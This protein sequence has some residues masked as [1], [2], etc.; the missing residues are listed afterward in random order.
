[1]KNAFTIAFVLMAFWLPAQPLQWT[2][3]KDGGIERS[4]IKGSFND[5]LEMSGKQ[6]SAIIYYGVDSSG[7]LL[8]RRRLVFP[9]LRTI[10]NDTHASLIQD[11]AGNP[12]A[13]A[14]INGEPL[15]ETPLRF[16]IQ[17]GLRVVTKAG[18][19][20]IERQIFPTVDKAA[21]LEQ[22]Q[23]RNDADQ[24]VSLTIPTLDS[25]YT[26]E[27]AKGVDGAYTLQQKLY[28]SADIR[29]M[30]GQTHTCWLVIS[31]RKNVQLPYYYSAPYEWERRKEKLAGLQQKLILQ[32]PNDT[33]NRMFAFAKVRAVESIYDTRE[34]L[35]HGPGGERY[36]AAIWA[37]DQAEYVNPFFAYLGDATGVESA[38]NSFRLFARYINPDFKPIPSSITAEGQDIWNGAGDRGDQAMIGYGASFFALTLGDKST[39]TNLWP[40]VS[41]CNRYLLKQQTAE[42][43][44]ASA[45]DELEGRFPAGK[46]NL[47]TNTLAYGSF[48]YSAR[49]A[50]WLGMADSALYWQQ[51]ANALEQHIETYFGAVVEGFNTYRYYDGNDK[52]RSWICLPL[53]MGINRRRDETTRALLSPQMWTKNG[54]LTQSGS[55][56]FWDRATLYA[57]R[58]LFKAGITDTAMR[59]FA[60]YSAHRL[61]GDHVPYAVEAWPEGNQRH[62]SAESG[63]YCRTLVEGLFG[64]DPVGPKSFTLSPTMPQGWPVMSL[65]KVHAF[66]TV[67]N[68]IVQ[69]NQKGYTITVHEQGQQP[70]TKHWNGQAPLRFALKP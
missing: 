68:I 7:Q 59:Y 6:I 57:F 56:T 22:Y 27:A 63:L 8:L 70:Q 18:K 51:Q 61:L 55:T 25:A 30:P 32:T 24:P 11:F 49:L 42:G 19:L 10:P 12:L 9:L 43:V 58:G 34:G 54:I 40:L 13:R 20:I 64:F 52:L 65:S 5:H 28:N 26:T 4:W 38:R 21:L 31:G 37:N 48:V 47:S 46:V 66:A 1:M 41:W 53:T 62:L 17:Q 69:R 2:M 44:I 15:H 39:A 60:Y 36:Y 45:S 35:M 16:Y 23:I 3:T 67:F 29:L 33:I 50:A 14:T